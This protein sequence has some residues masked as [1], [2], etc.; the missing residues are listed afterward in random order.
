MQTQFYS[1]AK[2]VWKWSSVFAEAEGGPGSVYWVVTL[3]PDQGG[4]HG[5]DRQAVPGA[6]PRVVDFFDRERALIDR[7]QPRDL[8][9]TAVL[10]QEAAIPFDQDM[11]PYPAGMGKRE[12]YVRNCMT[13]LSQRLPERRD[14]VFL[15]PDNGMGNTIS[16]GRQVHMRHLRLLW[17]ALRPGDVLMTIQFPWFRKNWVQALANELAN[18]LGVAPE[19]VRT[20]AWEKRLALYAVTK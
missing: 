8:A 1:D 7:G 14:V 17:D 4:N 15:D 5:S 11:D 2:D 18:A 3:R 10:F 16:N 19:S 9:R 20:H 13:W 12:A 6:D